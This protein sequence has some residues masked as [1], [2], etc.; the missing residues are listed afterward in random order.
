[1][2]KLPG[3][4]EILS[5]REVDLKAAG[6]RARKSLLPAPER[7]R[8]CP[9]WPVRGHWRQYRSGKRVYIAPF[10]K[11]PERDIRECPGREFTV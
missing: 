7:T 2:T 9:V 11:G 6:E 3:K 10:V 8:R 4:V 5:I 1:M